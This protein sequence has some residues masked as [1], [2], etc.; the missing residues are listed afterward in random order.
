MHNSHINKH[1]ENK[2]RM[3]RQIA[4]YLSFITVLFTPTSRVNEHETN[5]PKS[6][7]RRLTGLLTGWLTD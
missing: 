6:L 2:P 7:S 1:H 4:D 5:T 3:R